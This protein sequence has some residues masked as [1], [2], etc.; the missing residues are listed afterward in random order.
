[1]ESQLN[2]LKNCSKVFKKNNPTGPCL[3]MT[4]V[5]VCDEYLLKLEDKIV[6]FAAI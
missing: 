3:S 2:E 4:L 5:L 6:A 1:M